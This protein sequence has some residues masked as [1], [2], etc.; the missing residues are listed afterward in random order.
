MKISKIITF[1]TLM[2]AGLNATAQERYSH[3]RVYA[4]NQVSNTISV[5]DPSTNKFLGEIVLGKPYP[6]V[7]NPLYKGAALVHGLRYLPA[8]KMLA[9][10]AIGSNSLTL[11]STETNEVIKTIYVG[12]SPHEPTFTPDGKQ[13]WISVRGEAYV[14]VID[15]AKLAE[16]KQVPVADGPGMISFTPDGKLAYVCSSFTA[17]VDIVN[18]ST[19]QVI[20]KIPVVS[21]FSPNIFTSPHGEWIAMTH[22]DVGKVTIIDTRKQTVAKVLTTGAITNHVTFCYVD[23]KLK[24]LVTVGGENKVRVFSPETDFRQT[25]TISVG[26]LPHGIWPSADGKVAYVGLEYGDQVQGIDLLTMKV[27]PPVKIGQSP[28]ALVYADNAVTDPNNHLNL[29]PLNDEASTSI[30][31]LTGTDENNL[32]KGR[33]AVRPIGLADLIEQ[34]FTSLKPNTGYTLFLTHSKSA[35]FS[36]DYELNSFTT[37]PA[38][39][40][41]GQS[42]GL[43]RSTTGNSGANSYAHVVLTDNT[44]GQTVLYDQNK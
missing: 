39:K 9:V 41:N 18:T 37:D 42:T 2:S 15:V 22:K 32:A 12:R 5:V 19:Y 17:E 43:I 14:S 21:P 6:G 36:K 3:D 38:G 13:I 8:K 28:Q 26:A 34:I 29:K 35:P 10:I 44:S 25:D 24:M 27:M 31:T 7:L 11:V 30:I 20:K 40:Y 33:L 1:I 16:V 4:A 23:N